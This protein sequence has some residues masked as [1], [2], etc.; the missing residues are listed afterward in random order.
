MITINVREYKDGDATALCEIIRKDILTENIKDY[1]K[2]SI[3][4]LIQSH[5]EDFIKKDQNGVMF[6]F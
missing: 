3:G 2:S 5:D 6:R 1:P 4:K